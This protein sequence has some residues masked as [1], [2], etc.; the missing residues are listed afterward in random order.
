[1]RG[2]MAAQQAEELER[3]IDCV[4]AA[5]WEQEVKADDP[6]ALLAALENA[7]LDAAYYQE[8]VEDPDIK[9]ALMNV[10]QEAIDRGVFGMSTFFVGDEMFFGKDSM[11]A[12][13]R[14]ISL[15]A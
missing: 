8:K 3:Y 13:E 12:V 5:M 11:A 9:A 6:A 2:C 10:T 4:M 1:M 7:G 14:E 15:L